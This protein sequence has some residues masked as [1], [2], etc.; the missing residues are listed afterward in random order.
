MAMVTK[1]AWGTATRVVGDKKGDGY[2]NDKK[3]DG[4]SNKEGNGN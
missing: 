4:N 1:R 2:G 3:K